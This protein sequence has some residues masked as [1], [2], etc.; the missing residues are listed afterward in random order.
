MR[1]LKPGA[2]VYTKADN[3]LG[4]SWEGERVFVNP[5]YGAI[6]KWIAKCAGEQER[7]ELITLLIFARTETKYFH[8]YIYDATK[9]KFRSGIT[10]RFIPKRLKFINLNDFGD[11]A[12]GATFPSILVIFR[13]TGKKPEWG[14]FE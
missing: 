14:G 9:W 2:K 13:P 12:Q 6:D 7:A 1:I 8:K 4:R 3:G 5:P 10:C 11:Q